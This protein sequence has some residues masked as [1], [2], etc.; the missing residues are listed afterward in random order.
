M[1]MEA[2][3]FD[4]M[5]DKFLGTERTYKS[6]YEKAEKEHERMTGQ[7]RYEDHESYRVGR[8]RRIKRRK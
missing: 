1:R 8:F 7:R 4:E 6:A 2:R 3:A 5:V